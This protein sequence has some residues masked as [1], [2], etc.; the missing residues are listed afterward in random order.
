MEKR[1]NGEIVT[2]K[3]T[4]KMQRTDGQTEEQRGKPRKCEVRNTTTVIGE[5]FKD[6]NRGAK[7]Y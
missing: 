1:N 2:G 7:K 4:E 5:K 6:E 3:L